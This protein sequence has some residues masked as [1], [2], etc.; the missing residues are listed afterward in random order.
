MA[1]NRLAMPFPSTQKAIGVIWA[2]SAGLRRPA[3]M[4]VEPETGIEAISI[5]SNGNVKSMIPT[6]I[7]S[8]I[9]RNASNRRTSSAAAALPCSVRTRGTK[10]VVASSKPNE[11]I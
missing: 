11:T 6:V 8:V 2:S 5:A 3:A 9:R 1:M 4:P 7:I 10:V